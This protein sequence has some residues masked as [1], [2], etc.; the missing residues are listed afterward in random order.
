MITGPVGIHRQT[1]VR[2]VLKELGT[3]NLDE[4]CRSGKVNK[5]AR[6]KPMDMPGL[7]Y[8]AEEGSDF[9]QGQSKKVYKANGG[10]FDGTYLN[11]K[12]YQLT[13]CGLNFLAF[14]DAEDLA[15]LYYKYTESNPGP[16]ANNWEWDAPKGTINS[17][18]RLTDFEKYDHDT[19]CQF[20]TDVT[21]SP[22]TDK[23]GL[24]EYNAGANMPIDCKLT[25][26]G[27]GGGHLGLSLKEI[28][29]SAGGTNVQFAVMV[30]SENGA[31]ENNAAD[32]E[33]KGSIVSAIMYDMT[34]LQ[35]TPPKMTEGDVFGVVYMV[36]YV[37]DGE[38][39][40][41]TLTQL[42]EGGTNTEKN[43]TGE[44][45]YGVKRFVYANHTPGSI[46]LVAL[47]TYHTDSWANA[48]NI[49]NGTQMKS[50]NLYMKYQATAN[51]SAYIFKAK[52][53]KYKFFY[54]TEDGQYGD[55]EVDASVR[56]DTIRVSKE[57]PISPRGNNDADGIRIETAAGNPG[58]T[59]IYIT[60][61]TIDQAGT[62]NKQLPNGSKLYQMITEWQCGD[63]GK[64][65][66]LSSFNPN[67]VTP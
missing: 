12:I 50:T 38:T 19:G 63:G 1:D 34:D 6:F 18:Y 58:G 41:S 53:V 31:Y 66:N 32:G 43:Y 45:R 46:S 37:K 61:P 20:W 67:I 48:D 56:S 55:F 57:Q 62:N 26:F 47:K 9:W 7:Y 8:N 30:F 22:D 24:P 59:T 25:T 40:Y 42:L 35:I 49:Q 39:L 15:N 65:E 27:I 11:G 33:Q 52:H 14:T 23:S 21:R 51:G 16:F 44:M 28:I 64:W 17:P 10:Q 29:E 60:I 13:A 2:G 36:K 54:V 3:G 4:L 5:W